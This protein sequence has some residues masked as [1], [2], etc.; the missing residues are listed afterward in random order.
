MKAAPQ[1]QGV[2]IDISLVNIVL[3]HIRSFQ[4]I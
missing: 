2:R 1:S 3:N 4:I